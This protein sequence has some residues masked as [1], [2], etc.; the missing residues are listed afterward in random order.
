MIKPHFTTATTQ[1]IVFPQDTNYMPPL[2]FG[3]KMLAEMD[4][5]A[6]ITAKKALWSVGIERAVTVA[7][8]D[9]V[10]R[11][12]AKVGDLIVLDGTLT[13]VGLKSLTMRVVGHRHTADTAEK[14]CEGTFI[15]VSQRKPSP[16]GYSEVEP[17]EF[18]YVT[19]R[20]GL[21]L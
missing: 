1:F 19:C 9:V 13:K 3:G 20:H 21:T 16:E 7:V 17:D 4:L 11:K 10:F 14:M 12:G 2:V 8:Q 15:M 6:A 5:C 18:G